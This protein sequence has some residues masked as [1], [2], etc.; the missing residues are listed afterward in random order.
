MLGVN[1]LFMGE[2]W[3]T[4]DRECVAPLA[5]TSSSVVKMVPG[6][7]SAPCSYA[8]AA[9]APSFDTD[10][11]GQFDI[12]STPTSFYME[13]SSPSLSKCILE[14]PTILNACGKVSGEII[15]ATSN[16]IYILESAELPDH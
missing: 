6:S 13:P 15:Q 5:E 2:F 4:V 10:C 7:V 12:Y 1:T 16:Y 9:L 14:D 8:I 3:N 11:I